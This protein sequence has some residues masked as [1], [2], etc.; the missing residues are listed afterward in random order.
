VRFVF[1]QSH[2]ALHSLGDIGNVAVAP[3]ADL[4][5]EDPQSASATA[6]D[7]TFGHNAASVAAEAR[8]GRLLDDEGLASCM[9][10]KGRV[11]EV[12][13][14]P[15]LQPCRRCLEDT[16]VEPHELTSGS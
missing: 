9:D 10:L 16:T 3:D 6:A 12:A 7:R 15:S 8:D 14:W 2:R 11:V 4:I 13:R 5:P 1:A